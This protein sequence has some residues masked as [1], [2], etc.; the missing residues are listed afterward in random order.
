[1]KKV[2]LPLFV[3][4]LVCFALNFIQY[5]PCDTPIKYK[6]GNIDK[7][8][9]ITS[10]QFKKDT[11]NASSIW[12]KIINKNVFTYDPKGN[13]TINAVYDE[14]QALNNQINTL[15]GKLKTGETTLD[16]QIAK[17]QKDL[18][19]FNKSLIDLN[20]QIDAWNAKGGA[21][22]DVYKALLNQQSALKAEASRLNALAKSLNQ[23]TSTYNSQVLN[24]NNKINTFN[25]SLLVKPEEGLYD[26]ETNTI[27]IY[28][29]ISQN[30]LIHT[31]AHELGHARGLAHTNGKLDIMY[32]E[33][34]ESLIASQNDI[35]AIT[36]ICK[37]KS[38]LQAILLTI[39]TR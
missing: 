10:E 33:S 29:D 26:S 9:N 27:N 11:N 23:Q 22:P 17:Y 39:T 12:N 2:L 35:N 1:M 36:L 14:R 31:L 21:P 7:R 30:E 8:F 28:F 32:P 15:E 25:E 20:A 6:I 37:K 24:V 18:A 16:A 34:G 3:F 5:S 19:T 13:L 38:L 4:I